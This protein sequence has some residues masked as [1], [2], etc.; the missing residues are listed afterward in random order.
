MVTFPVDPG[1]QKCDLAQIQMHGEI[2]TICAMLSFGYNILVGDLCQAA[3]G[4]ALVFFTGQ[5][6]IEAAGKKFPFDQ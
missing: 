2:L 1:L 5:K 6:E 4:G 3:P